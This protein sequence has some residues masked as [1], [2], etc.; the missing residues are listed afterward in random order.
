MKTSVRKLESKNND[1]NIEMKNHAQYLF[2]LM[3][4]LKVELSNSFY[5][6]IILK[7]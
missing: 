6:S 7:G 1:S 2:I 4:L 3:S 5:S